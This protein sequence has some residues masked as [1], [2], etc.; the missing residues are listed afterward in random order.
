MQQSRL[1]WEISERIMGKAHG[2]RGRDTMWEIP[3]DSL[4][5]ILKQ[6]QVNHLLV[7]LELSVVI[8]F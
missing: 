8:I 4:Y 7:V 2:G 3:V 6:D 1:I 5:Q